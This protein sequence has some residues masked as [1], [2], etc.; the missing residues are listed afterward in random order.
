M[1]PR[2]VLVR[3]PNPSA[4]T[5]SGTNSYLIDCGNGQAVCIDPGPPLQRHVRALLD[6]AAEMQCDIV[7]IA[8]THTHPDHAP[9]AL[10]LAEQTG[11]PIAAH[12]QT[13]FP[14]TRNLHDGDVLQIG[15]ATLKV[16]ESPGHTFDHL[17]YYEE[18]EGALFTGDVVLGEGFVV[19]APPNGAMRPYQQTLHRLLTEFPDA[20]T[21]YG[22]HGEPVRDPQVKLREYIAHRESRQ[23]EILTTLALQ[24]LTI[25]DLVRTIYHG[26]NPI[27]WPAA[28]RQMLAYLI[29]LEQE[30]RIV[31]RALDRQMNGAE[32]AILNP[33]WE[34]IVGKEHA[35]TVEEELGAMLRLDTLREYRLAP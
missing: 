32:H 35:R 30:G 19:I 23:E 18:R 28:A 24:P 9:A 22:G 14:H 8:L 13:E 29:P 21:I 16:I 20:K 3:A 7:L 4:M 31:S 6:R 33:E 12:A 17:A 2:V 11:A 34:T 15:D 10:S 5:L 1:R 26:T 27:L 25:P